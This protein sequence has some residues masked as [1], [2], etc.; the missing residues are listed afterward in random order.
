MKLNKKKIAVVSLIVCIIAILSLGSLAWYTANDTV[1]NTLSFVTNFQMDLIEHDAEGQIVGAD[2]DTTG[3]TFTNVRPN[4]EL[5]K[6]PTVINKSAAEDQWVRMSVTVSKASE[7]AKVVTAGSDLS[8]IFTGFD[9]T[10]WV[11]YGAA[12]E[13][14]G[15]TV[16]Y[17]YYLNEKLAAGKSATLFTGIHIPKNITD[18]SK[19]DGTTITVKAEAMQASDLGAGVKDAYTAFNNPTKAK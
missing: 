5:K 14:S 13:I 16:T 4:A 2:G 6:D 7:W 10:A 15:D 8:E 9:D 11:R 3:I 12:P 1:V 19:L 17:T 18:G